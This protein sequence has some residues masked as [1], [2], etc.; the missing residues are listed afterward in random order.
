MNK[1]RIL[2]ISLTWKVRIAFLFLFILFCGLGIFSMALLQQ[3]ENITRN[4]HNEAMG[5]ANLDKISK[6][7]TDER[8]LY[9]NLILNESIEELSKIDKLL[10]KTRE[11][12]DQACKNYEN[13]IF[14]AESSQ[15]FEAFLTLAEAYQLE[16]DVVFDLALQG[17]TAQARVYMQTVADNAFKQA[18]NYIEQLRYLNNRISAQAWQNASVVY[19]KGKTVLLLATIMVSIGTLL[20][21]RFMRLS[22][23]KPILN[24]TEAITRLASWDM[25]VVIPEQDRGDELGEMANAITALQKTARQQQQTSWIK[26]KLQEIT[27]E[28]Q[29]AEEIEEFA[30]A[31]LNKLSPILEAQVA[32]FYSLDILEESF[33][34]AGSYGF[35]PKPGHPAHFRAGEG[36]IGQCALGKAAITLTK[37]PPD[38]ISITSGIVDGVPHELFIA[39]IL[40]SADKVLAIME[41]ATIHEIGPEQHNLLKELLPILGLN[42]QIIERNQRTKELLKESQSQAVELAKQAEQI[43]SDQYEL[44]NQH[45]ELIKVNEQLASKTQE[46]KATLEKLEEATKVKNIFLANM[47]HEIRTPMNAVIGMSHLCLKTELSDKQK[48]YVEKIQQAGFSLLEIINNILDFSRIEDGNM[49]VRRSLFLV[50][51]LLEKTTLEFASKAKNKGIEFIT[52]IDEN[53][54]PSLYGD[55]LRIG[56][57]LHHLLSNA[58]KFTEN[59]HV[60]LKIKTIEHHDSQVKLRFEV[61]DTGIGMTPEHLAQL[62]QPFQQADASATRQFSGAGIGLALSKRLAEMMGG[63]ILANSQLGHGATFY[64]EIWCGLGAMSKPESINFSIEG[65]RALVVDDNPVDRQILTEQL[66]SVGLRVDVCDSGLESLVAIEKAD[67]NDPFKV[68]FMDWRLPGVDGIDIIS[69]IDKLK[70]QN[71]KP[72]IVLM[73]A[74]EIDDVRDQAELAGVRAFLPKPVTPTNLWHSLVKAFGSTISRP[75]PS[76]VK[77]Y[78]PKDLRGLR[79]LLVE[80]NDLNQQIA[81]ELLQTVGVEVSLA[82]NGKI[83]VEMLK[84]APDPLPYDL[85]LMDIQM[86]VMD[87][88]QATIE[89]RKDPRFNELPIIALTAHA[90]EDEKQLCFEEGMNGHISK[91]I[92]PHL[93][94][95]LLANWVKRQPETISNGTPELDSK[96]G[97]RRVAGNRQLY[98]SLLQKFSEGQANAIE[99]IRKAAADGDANVAERTAHTLKGVAGNIGATALQNIA[100]KIEKGLKNG[101]N[102]A[103]LEP[104]LAQCEDLF[105][106]TVAAITLFTAQTTED[107]VKKQTIEPAMTEIDASSASRLMKRFHYLLSQSDGEAEDYLEQNKAVLKSLLGAAELDR[108]QDSLSRFDFDEALKHL[109]TAASAKKLTI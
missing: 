26:A 33:V 81:K 59:G 98:A 51:E 97:M 24:L 85:L 79:V 83:A 5:F 63:Q 64:F 76:E 66:N 94:F 9:A 44:Q 92:E 74:F 27:S 1:D 35:I 39:P 29:K 75:A 53:L 3:L 19:E 12:F 89:I 20:I 18:F 14:S 28:T 6:A 77:K 30:V 31:L 46:T 52:S 36:L 40:A 80:D 22:I 17:K 11:E 37:I 95:R 100:G 56:Q 82:D 68:V 16:T 23:F 65:F 105:K 45:Y 62:F 90:M 4:V 87:G 88:H 70:T 103:E 54:P 60:E 15:L 72:A 96:A 7:M 107:S 78:T 34:L 102:I 25:N 99:K 106:K 61:A 48:D 73:T 109:Q 101:I 58:V 67:G 104:E 69:Q 50:A 57:I 32:A 2:K 86:P 108:L 91:P 38:Y 49:K 21:A 42:L 8:Y 41:F 10:V 47:S 55:Q 93:L 84:S 43:F 13:S 71:Q